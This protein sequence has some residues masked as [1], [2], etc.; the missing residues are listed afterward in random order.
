MQYQ[1]SERA[2]T[3]E[4]VTPQTPQ[5]PH[6]MRA[7]CR[8]QEGVEEVVGQPNGKGG[9]HALH[10]LRELRD[11]DEC[12]G[13]ADLYPLTLESISWLTERAC[14]LEHNQQIN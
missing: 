8:V 10:P 14:A 2:Q 5:T 3:P 13:T 4:P 11:V 6:T 1:H 12:H 7:W 9:V